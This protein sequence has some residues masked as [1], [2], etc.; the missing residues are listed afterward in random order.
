MPSRSGNWTGRAGVAAV[1]VFRVCVGGA[2]SSGTRLAW[3][4]GCTVVES[5]NALRNCFLLV[6]LIGVG[7]LEDVVG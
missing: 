1:L 5:L 4:I 6:I 7:I 2:V 3:Y